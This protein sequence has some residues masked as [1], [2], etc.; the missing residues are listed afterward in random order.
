MKPKL[1]RGYIDGL[2]GESDTLFA[3]GRIILSRCARVNFRT[4]FGCSANKRGRKSVTCSG[5]GI[6]PSVQC[7]H[8]C[9][10]RLVV[11][12]FV[13]TSEAFQGHWWGRIKGKVGVFVC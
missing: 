13:P 10:L 6:A 3:D 1:T 7:C 5:G 11:L 9:L 4:G 8:G 12:T 2:I